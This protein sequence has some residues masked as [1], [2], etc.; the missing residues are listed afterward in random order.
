MA[1]DINT[2]RRIYTEEQFI[3]K[4]PATVKATS[5][6]YSR[7]SNFPSP[8]RPVPLQPGALA[9]NAAVVALP[10]VLRS[11]VTAIQT[12]IRV[13]DDGPAVRNSVHSTNQRFDSKTTL[14]G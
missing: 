12:R 1:I 14:R 13:R 9:L 4:I 7:E 6:L 10:I 8:F 2:P 5:Q 11:M 3:E